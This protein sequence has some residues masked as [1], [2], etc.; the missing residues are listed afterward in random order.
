MMKF[1]EQNFCS[2]VLDEICKDSKTLKFSTLGK[3]MYGEDNGS[4]KCLEV[5]GMWRD[6]RKFSSELKISIF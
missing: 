1:V 5:F 3:N 2:P 4:Q 6:R